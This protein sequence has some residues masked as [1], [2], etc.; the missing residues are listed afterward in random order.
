M[1]CIGGFVC[2]LGGHSTCLE[3]LSAFLSGDLFDLSKVGVVENGLLRSGI[4]QNCECTFVFVRSI[5]WFS[6]GSM[7]VARSN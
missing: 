2:A 5:S 7:H 3:N 6:L 1:V 4:F